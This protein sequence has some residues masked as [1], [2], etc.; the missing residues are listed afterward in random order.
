MTPGGGRL[1]LKIGI[2]LPRGNDMHHKELTAALL[3]LIA[4]LPLYAQKNTEAPEAITNNAAAPQK[5]AA[6]APAAPPAAPAASPVTPAV[7]ESAWKDATADE[8]AA[9]LEATPEICDRVKEKWDTTP[10][11]QRVLLLKGVASLAN[12]PLKHQWAEATPEER[13]AFLSTIP[14][15]RRRLKENW[16]L[17]TPEQ[18]RQFVTKRPYSG[19]TKLHHGWTDATPEEQTAFLASQ[20]DLSRGMAR[21][22]ELAATSPVKS[23]KNSS[24]EEQTKFLQMNFYI[25]ENLQKRWQEISPTARAALVRRWPGWK[26]KSLAIPAAAGSPATAKSGAPMKKLE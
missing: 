13:V 4:T 9:F 17:L 8:K 3:F 2:C 16:D 24:P 11:K 22:W 7:F 21:I 6:P 25:H 20:L 10:S 15:L 23:W 5:A 18:K 1:I 19:R 26:I 14:P 12:R